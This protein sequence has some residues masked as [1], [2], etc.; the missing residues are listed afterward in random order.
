MKVAFT[1]GP[2]GPPSGLT[3]DRVVEVKAPNLKSHEIHGWGCRVAQ[4][5]YGD[6][7]VE[8]VSYPTHPLHVEAHGDKLEGAGAVIRVAP[9][10]PDFYDEWLEGTDG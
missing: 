1:I 9:S 3:V 8:A 4:K 5:F 10:K 6:V 7:Y 2:N